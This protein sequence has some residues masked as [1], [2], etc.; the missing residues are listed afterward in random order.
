MI[1]IRIFILTVVCLLVAAAGFSAR[2]VGS[3]PKAQPR[4]CPADKVVICGHDIVKVLEMLGAKRQAG[5]SDNQIRSYA[6][7]FDRSD[8]NHDGKHTRAEYV[9]GGKYMT[10]RAR[11]GI[12]GATDNNADGLV[13][14]TE[15]VLNRIITDEAKAIVGKT[16]ADKNGKVT[17]AE[18]V[19]GSPIA[20]KTL[21]GAVYDAL[22]TNGDKVITIPEYLRVWGGW[23][24][25]NYKAQEAKLASRIAKLGK[26]GGK[27]SGKPDG[28]DK[29]KGSA[30]P[31][32]GPPSVDRIFKIMDSN[33]DGKLT[34]SEFRGPEFVFTGADKN[35]DGVVTRKEM[36]TFR[37]NAR[38]KG[39]PGS[40]KQQVKIGQTATD[41]ELPV[42]IERTDA[43][44]EKVA[45]VTTDKIKLSSFRGK[46]IVCVFMSSYT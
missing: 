43:K 4:K 21:A 31:S 25:P 2:P 8:P 17:R 9:D 37:S 38:T 20:D 32:G 24:R 26:G 3:K 39:K 34:K 46:K 22:D 19:K 28:G 18:F 6:S 33:K 45:V 41:F 11:A 5:A 35:K 27:P 42:L 10:P 13:T 23:A 14:R 36:E 30:K 15:Y 40:R 7:H 44:G 29:G 12:F 16:D 1:R